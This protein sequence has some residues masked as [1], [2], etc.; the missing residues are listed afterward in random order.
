MENF[1]E[2]KFDDTFSD[3][4]RMTTEQA[5]VLLDFIMEMQKDNG[6]PNLRYPAQ[7]EADKT[8][9]ILRKRE[10]NASKALPPM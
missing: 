3:E 2:E 5:E 6:A 8:N 9:Y 4:G 10:K 7:Q 1:G